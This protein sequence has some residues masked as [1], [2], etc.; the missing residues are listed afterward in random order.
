MRR[1]RDELPNVVH[2]EALAAA[3]PFKYTAPCKR[4]GRDP[5]SYV[6][7]NRC[8]CEPLFHSSFG[9][10]SL[11]VSLGGFWG[12]LRP[13]VRGPLA[14]VEFAEITLESKRC[15]AYISSSGWVCWR[16]RWRCLRL[17][18][19]TMRLRLRPYHAGRGFRGW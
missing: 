7:Q 19:A 9:R 12:P 18:A 11:A 14:W 6:S 3:S 1:L 4:G 8:K 15:G 2:G 5:T 17:P 10:S 13:K 16:G